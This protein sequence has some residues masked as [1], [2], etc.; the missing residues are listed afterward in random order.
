MQNNYTLLASQM[1]STYVMYDE[2][3][4][5]MNRNRI[6][7]DVLVTYAMVSKA[8]W[9]RLVRAERRSRELDKIAAERLMASYK[10]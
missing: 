10:D 6:E 3:N 9:Q 1:A 2:R 7:H 8:Q 4:D 5:A